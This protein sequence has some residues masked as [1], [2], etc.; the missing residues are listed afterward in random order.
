MAAVEPV[1]SLASEEHTVTC[2]TTVVRLRA[3]VGSISPELA[4]VDP[5]LAA[6]LQAL[7]P[8]PVE[9][10]PYR[11]K[12]WP[13]I[14]V[15]PPELEH[16]GEH[17]LAATRRAIPRATVWVAALVAVLVTAFGLGAWRSSGGEGLSST[18]APSKERVLFFAPPSD[19]DLTPEAIAAL[20]SQAHSEPRS[21]FARE[22]LGT[23]YLR[24]RRWGDA[25]VELRALVELS[26][27]D[28]YA[29]FALG[30]ALA[31]QGRHDEAA[32]HFAEADALSRDSSPPAP[33]AR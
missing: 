32:D 12:S 33:R 2:P 19:P 24:L 9:L 13:A 29:H 14:L 25:E 1:L 31:E 30:R 20:E 28:A 17:E 22:A 18:S 5:S 21:P 8:D 3:A 4:L 26:P 27:T 23:V 16:E 15:L 10:R 6:R 11:R 7:L